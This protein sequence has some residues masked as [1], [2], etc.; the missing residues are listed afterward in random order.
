MWA[1]GAAMGR[2]KQSP[3]SLHCNE[4]M[5]F[6]AVMLGR[7]TRRRLGSMKPEKPVILTGAFVEPV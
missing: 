6:N 1:M 5:N 2:E 4:S 7:N 3:H